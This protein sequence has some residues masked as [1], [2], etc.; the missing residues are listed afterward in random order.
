MTQRD[1]AARHTPSTLIRSLIHSLTHTLVQ[2]AHRAHHP[3]ARSLTRSPT[4]SL[5]RLS[6]WPTERIILMLNEMFTA[7]DQICAEM[8][9]YKVETIGESQRTFIRALWVV[10]VKSGHSWRTCPVSMYME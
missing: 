5:T 7:F 10:R 4:H 9:V 3:H 8:G 6:R 2:V 1:V